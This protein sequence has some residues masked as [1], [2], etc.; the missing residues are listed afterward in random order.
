M[1]RCTQIA[2]A[3]AKGAAADAGIETPLNEDKQERVGVIVGT[4]IG[5]IDEADKAIR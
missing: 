1:A 4:A 2:V 3:A 5:G